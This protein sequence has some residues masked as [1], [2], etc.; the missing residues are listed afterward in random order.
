MSVMPWSKGQT[1]EVGNLELKVENIQEEKP[2]WGRRY[3]IRLDDR[4]TLTITTYDF[5]GSRH[6]DGELRQPNGKYVTFQPK[7]IADK[8]IDRTLVPLVERACDEILALDRAYA[9]SNHREFV[10]VDG[11]R[12]ERAA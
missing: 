6:I 7:E 4:A 2:Q 12:W 5:L 9:S 10:D 8:I 11:T 1:V 3:V